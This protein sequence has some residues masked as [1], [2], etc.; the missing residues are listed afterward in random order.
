MAFPLSDAEHIA[1]KRRID[2]Q[3]ELI[4]AAAI[5]YDGAVIMV[6]RPGRHGNCLNWLSHNTHI[7]RSIQHECGFLTNRGRFVEREE[8][9]RIVLAE[10]QGSPGGTPVNN[11]RMCLFSEDMWNE[12]DAEE[13]ETVLAE[14][15]F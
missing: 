15:I 3:P 7:Q 1:I 12:R 11:P 5:R 8:A 13:C 2:S 6:E 9:G 4:V 10:A 14:Q